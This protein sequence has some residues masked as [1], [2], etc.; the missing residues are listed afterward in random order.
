VTVKNTRPDAT[1]D[2]SRTPADAGNMDKIR[3]LLVGPQMRDHERKVARLEERLD[4]ELAAMRDELKKGLGLFE[5][6]IKQEIET[7]SNRLRTEQSERKTAVKTLDDEAKAISERLQQASSQLDEQLSA[8]QRDL[9]QQLL[10]QQRRLSDEIRDRAA[11]GAQA[12]KR[13]A[14]ELRLLK[15]DRA[16]LAALFTEVAMRLNDEFDLPGAEHLRND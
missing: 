6:F 12:L 9:R 5:S 10:E 11:D 16:A 7:L 13:E 1:A 14:D 4:R 15:T 3:D 8:S 2:E